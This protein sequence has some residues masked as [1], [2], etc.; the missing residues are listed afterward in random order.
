[1]NESSIVSFF[2]SLLDDEIENEIIKLISKGLSEDEIIE[3]L[4]KVKKDGE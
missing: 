3:I 2:D 1:V 4:L